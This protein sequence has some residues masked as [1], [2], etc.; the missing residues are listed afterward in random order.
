[1]AVELN[2]VNGLNPVTPVTPVKPEAA[3]QKVAE[4]AKENKKVEEGVVYEKGNQE[5]KTTYTPESIAKQDRS[6]IIE[7]MKADLDQRK[8][9]MLDLVKKTLSGQVGAFSLANEDDIWKKLAS[10]D[11]TVD[12][13]TKKQAQE[14]ISED[15]YWGVKKTSQRLFDFAKALS[16]G[17]EAKM[18]KMQE[19]M[20]KGFK[21]ATKSWGQDL[22]EISKNTLEAA[23]KLFDDYYASLAQPEEQ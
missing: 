9:Q 20:E 8:Q 1:M 13:A 19:A 17:D 23:N 14:D 11:F 15:G 4:E 6:S 12:A 3:V 2:G 7:Q 22:P 10:G 5:A 21:E 18:K 16:G